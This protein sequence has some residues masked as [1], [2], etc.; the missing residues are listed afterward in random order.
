MATKATSV[1]V[2]HCGASLSEQSTAAFFANQKTS[3]V[4]IPGYTGHAC[5]QIAGVKSRLLLTSIGSEHTVMHSSYTN[6]RGVEKSLRMIN[7]Y[8]VSNCPRGLMI[9]RQ[10]TCN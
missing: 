1:N 7:Q 3:P 4:L 10:Y 5:L 9:M 6:R 2:E 8:T